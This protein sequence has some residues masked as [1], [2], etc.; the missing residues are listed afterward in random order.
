M[1]QKLIT[2]N[3]NLCIFYMQEK[4]LGFYIVI[5]NS[6]RV[7]IALGLFENVDEDFIKNIKINQEVAL[8]IPIIKADILKQSNIISS[9]SDKY[10]NQVLPFLI[11]TSYKILTYNKIEV[12]NQ[13]IL[14][15][16]YDLAIF[17]RNF[18]E[19]NQGRVVLMDLINKPI[20][21]ENIQINLQPNQIIQESPLTEMPKQEENVLL[22]EL[23]NENITKSPEVPHEPGF[24]SYVLLGVVIA[25]ATLAFLYFII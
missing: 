2:K 16:N 10:L 21:V 1:E 17:N 8:V 9:P 18:I 14:N 24:V 25:V 23:P 7:K 19:K 22:T 3:N 15:N 5:P 12:D 4:N 6:K 20:K 13:V 11:N